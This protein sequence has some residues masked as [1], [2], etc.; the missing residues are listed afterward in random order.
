MRKGGHRETTR[1]LWWQVQ[2]RYK[3]V[4]GENEW[5]WVGVSYINYG[6]KYDG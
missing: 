2:G 5:K 4:T 1:R 6:N 3:G